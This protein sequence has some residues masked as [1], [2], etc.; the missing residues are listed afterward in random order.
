MVVVGY[1]GGYSPHGRL[2]A[3]RREG[4]GDQ[5]A[6]KP[7]PSDHFL[8]LDHLYLLKFPPPPK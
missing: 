4:I 8:Q 5:V 2:E 6:F 3:E 7:L 1:R